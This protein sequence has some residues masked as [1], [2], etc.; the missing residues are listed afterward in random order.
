M[1]FCPACLFYNIISR[2]KRKKKENACLSDE[3]SV[4][5]G[6]LRFFPW[7]WFLS[8][9]ML[10]CSCF[11]ICCCRMLDQLYLPL[12]LWHS[13]VSYTSAGPLTQT[14]DCN[15]MKSLL[16]SK[17]TKSLSDWI[18]RFSYPTSLFSNRLCSNASLGAL[19]CGNP[20]LSKLEVM[21]GRAQ[22]VLFRFP[23]T[24]VSLSKTGWRLGIVYFFF[25]FLLYFEKAC[26]N[27]TMVVW[28]EN[29][30]G[31]LA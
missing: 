16:Y 3:I 13:A 8:L 15:L 19:P 1:I 10:M 27:Q 7:L 11:C 24:C 14:K 25:F 17:A 20:I 5:D 2:E 18:Q 29:C 31:F 26:T 22:A 30:C 4:S 28:N 9:L 21:L 6:S 23:I 12:A